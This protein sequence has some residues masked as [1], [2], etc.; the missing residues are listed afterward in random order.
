MHMASLKTGDAVYVVERQPTPEDA[1]SGLY[2]SYF[3]NL[4]GT[5]NKVYDDGSICLDIDIDSLPD[6]IRRRHEETEK[7]AKLKWLDNLSGEA[8]NRLSDD[9]KQFR[10]SYKILVSAK[11]VKAGKPSKPAGGKKESAAKAKP[12]PQPEARAEAPRKTD[13]SQMKAVEA[14]KTATA[15]PAKAEKP[16]PVPAPKPKRVTQVAKAPTSAEQVHRMTSKD[17]EKAEKAFLA[18][19]LRSQEKTSKAS[20]PK[21]GTHKTA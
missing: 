10:L 1:K 9:E 20:S 4:G 17:L 3:G 6:G 21:R 14:P 18:E 11:D 12:A 5:V 7:A 13:A 16:T 2:Y 8:R 19:R 15:A